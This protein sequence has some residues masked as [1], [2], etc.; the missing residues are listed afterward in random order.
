MSVCTE[1]TISMS[2]NR[3]CLGEKNR[4][5]D[6]ISI[7]VLNVIFT[8]GIPGYLGYTSGLS[9]LCMVFFLI[10]VSLFVNDPSAFTIKTFVTINNNKCVSLKK[11][12][13]Q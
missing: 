5:Y 10:V 9:L 8:S 1:C 2:N 3:V 6:D 11:N 4:M 13:L 12:T 7:C